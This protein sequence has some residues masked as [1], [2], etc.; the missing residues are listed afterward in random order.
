MVDGNAPV[1]RHGR[2]IKA[3]ARLQG[4]KELQYNNVRHRTDSGVKHSSVV[5]TDPTGDL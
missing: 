1:F 2:I 3:S 4:N 5:C